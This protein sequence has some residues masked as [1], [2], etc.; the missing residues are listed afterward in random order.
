[1]SQITPQEILLQMRRR[2]ARAGRNYKTQLLDQ[3]LELFGYHR[4]AAVHAPRPQPAPARAPVARGRPSEYDPDQLL[5]PLKA[6]RLATLQPCGVRLKACLPDW[7]PAYEEDQSPPGRPPA[8]E[9]LLSASRATLDRLLI[10][11]A[12]LAHR[13]RA[14]TRP[15]SWLRDEIALRPKW[16]EQTPAYLEVDPVALGGAR[17]SLDPTPG[18]RPLDLERGARAV[19]PQPSPC[20]PASGRC[21]PPAARPVARAGQQPRRGV[22]PPP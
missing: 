11:P 10:I 2:Y 9:A 14:A 16:P 21:P 12:R 3:A 19:Q 1:M 5:P 20:L 7:L 15:G 18:C 4:Q 17:Q 8:P 6:I 13:R 22:H